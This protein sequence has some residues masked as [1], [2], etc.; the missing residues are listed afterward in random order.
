M[1]MFLG[2]ESQAVPKK[3]KT[4][5]QQQLKSAIELYR[6]GAYAASE[7]LCRKLIK[8][9]GAQDGSGWHLLGAV[10]RDSKRTEEAEVC[11]RKAIDIDPAN[12]DA[13]ANLGLCC[14]DEGRAAEGVAWQ[15]K[16]LAI[17]PLH[18]GA[19][20]NL[21]TLLFQADKIVDAEQTF[22]R[23][24]Q[25]GRSSA[26][27][28][29][30]AA[31]RKKLAKADEAVVMYRHW[32]AEHPD[33]V[34][35]ITELGLTLL[36]L[37][38]WNEAKEML[39]LGRTLAPDSVSI[40]ANLGM[41][42]RT[43]FKYAA[44]LEIWEAARDL[45]PDK[46]ELLVNL[47]SLYR[48]LGRTR[49]AEVT[50]RRALELR[51]DY[52]NAHNN[53]GNVF[54][55]EGRTREAREAFLKCLEFDQQH[56]CAWS[57]LLFT[58]QNIG[59]LSAELLAHDARRFGAALAAAELADG[60]QHANDARP[61]RILRI[62]YLSPDFLT[63][64]VSYFIEPILQHHDRSKVHITCFAN[65]SAIDP[66]TQR[67]QKL[68]DN[69]HFVEDLD[70]E[71]LKALIVAE[72]IDI[73][74]D[75]AGH[76]AKNRL[77][78]FARQP[79]P[80]QVSWIGYPDTTGLAAMHYRLTDAWADPVGKTEAWHTEKLIRLSQGFLCYRPPPDAPEPA[81]P[82]SLAGGSVTFG[83][84]N[85]LSKVD[86]E[87]IGLWS[88]IL[89]AAPGSRLMLKSLA[90]DAAGC[91]E[92]YL[93]AFAERGIERSRLVLI[94]KI[95][96]MQEHLAK[97]GEVDIALDT[98]PYHGTTTT[99][100]ALWMGV[101]VVTLAGVRHVSRVGVSLLS[102]VGAEEL[103]ARDEAH[104]IALAVE[105]ASDP[106]RLATYRR[107]LRG[108]MASSPLCDAAG[109]TAAVES[110][111]RQMWRDW[112]APAC[113]AENADAGEIFFRLM[114]K[115]RISFASGNWSEAAT[116][117]RK[118]TVVEPAA[119]DAWANLG[120]A[121]KGMG[122]IEEALASYR[123]AL[124]IKPDSAMV[125]ANMGAALLNKGD[126][127]AAEAACR[128]S[129]R[130]DPG[131][132][133]G[134]VNLALALAAKRDYQG[135]LAE[136][137]QALEL[138]LKSAETYCNM[139]ATLFELGRLAEA[140]ACC[141]KALAL[142][143][144]FTEARANLSTILI[145]Q[146]RLAEGLAEARKVLEQRPGFA[147]ANSN[148]LMTMQ[149]D[150]TVT[151]AE[152]CNAHREWGRR[153]GGKGGGFDFRDREGEEER[154][155]RLGF[156]STDFNAHPV[157]FFLE[158]LLAQLDRRTVE[159][160][161]YAANAYTDLVTDR[162]RALADYW[163]VIAG[164]DA[165]A[166]ARLVYDDRID[167]LFDL[168]G[169]TR[170][171]RL[172]M[173]ALRPAPLQATWLGYP[174]TT[175]LPEM[176][177]RLSDQHADPAGRTDEWCTE[178]LVRLPQSFLCYQLLPGAPA[179]A[180]APCLA[181]EGLTFGS[182]NNLSK[183]SPSAIRL[184][185]RVLLAT[186]GARL[187]VKAKALTDEGARRRLAAAFARAGLGED[188][189]ELRGWTPGPL[190]HLDQYK[191]VDIALDT[192]PYHGT[193]TTCEALSM[194]VPVVTLAGERHAARVGAS[195]LNGAGLAELVA[196]DEN[197]Y[198]DIAVRL[199]SDKQRLTRLR[200]GMRTR[201]HA[202]PLCDAPRF[203]RDFAEACRQMWREW[204]AASAGDKQITITA[205]KDDTMQSA[206]QQK[207]LKLPLPGGI[208]VCVPDN[209]SLMTPYIL[210]EQQDWFEDEIHFVRRLVEPG[211]AVI[212][213]G[214]NYGVYTLTIAKAVGTEGHVW[215]FEPARE[216]ADYLRAS[217]A[218]NGFDQVELIRAALSD[219]EGEAH[220]STNA[221]AELNTL[222]GALD[223][224]GETV[225]LTVL[226]AFL[227]QFSRYEVAFVK[228]DA[229]GEEPN[230]IRGG[231]RFFAEQSPLVMFEIKDA[232]TPNLHLVELFDR[233]GYASYRLVPG[234]NILVPFEATKPV[235]PFQLNLFACKADRARLLAERGLL[236]EPDQGEA[237]PVPDDDLWHQWLSDQPWAVG[238]LPK[239]DRCLTDAGSDAGRRHRDALNLYVLSK[240]MAL[241]AAGRVA[242]LAGS[243][244]LLAPFATETPNLPR[245]SSLARVAA[246]FGQRGAAV[247]AM[248]QL[249]TLLQKGGS[250]DLDE[251]FLPA[252]PRFDLLAPA[253]RLADWIICS[254]I[255]TLEKSCRYSSYFGPEQSRT[256]LETVAK[257]AFIGVAAKR[258]LELIERLARRAPSVAVASAN[259]FDVLPR[260]EAMISIVDIG[261]MM[262][263]D[264]QGP[265]AALV[266]QGY[267]Q[268]IGFEPNEAEC[269]KLNSR[270]EGTHR[271]YPF[272]IGDGEQA[273][274]YETNMTM[275]GSLLRPNKRML[276]QFTNL[277][278]LVTLVGEHAV[279]TRRLDD[280][281]GLEDVDVVKI[282]VQGT[283]L[284]V[285][286]G[287]AQVLSKALF[288]HTEVE[289]VELYE[290]QPLFA[291]IDQFLRAAG[292][293]FHTFEGFGQRSFK[294][295]IVSQDQNR[296]LRQLLWSDA[297]YVRDFLKFD[298]LP[299]QK[300]LKLAIIAHEMYRSYDLAYR[301]L[302]CLDKRKGTTLA[303][304]YLLFLHNH[305]IKPFCDV[306]KN[307]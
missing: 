185:S 30:L 273:T 215:A 19:L 91:R 297:I 114:D 191:D 92:V 255:E 241:S 57:N 292:F 46:P 207:M 201:L 63:H 225:R 126:I 85:S 130:I 283:E 262:L 270:F 157:G 188:R 54:R 168:N 240:N 160:F 83:S 144:T 183:I 7:R 233:L 137:E 139:S 56:W 277:H 202:S 218:E 87:L 269:K 31:C 242:A 305:S 187:L 177:F 45:E 304:A 260:P 230:V 256:L 25:N 236:A 161:L 231:D 43:M 69:W 74:V 138:G 247:G 167:I 162:L 289:F 28:R 239:W 14:A 169:H 268:V 181:G 22:S 116:A 263:G 198:V 32:L 252:G 300:L 266:R 153:F 122:K 229:E 272:F 123:K 64:S 220:L 254:V 66:M 6:Q 93:Q 110:A 27:V 23:A 8:Q 206:T 214:A 235:D 26:A 149:Y 306:N 179:V 286:K 84:F 245:L 280:L 132:A 250:F 98:Y 118:A 221:N 243:Y 288:V 155:L 59:G 298:L 120:A 107:A 257:R 50:L 81:A 142:Q 90:L 33:D 9:A 40:L 171:N 209:L 159:I 124:E 48:D 248:N 29:G 75:L 145:A 136:Y 12:A 226:D 178:R 294:P 99:C 281:V 197:E 61:E 2:S 174:D 151:P 232:N 163:R 279:T 73:L 44:A 234:L 275:T 77:P 205:P 213:I 204:C 21:G 128:Q 176:D 237:F 284:A 105:L 129:L 96:T 274:F 58:S 49:E 200:E 199:A 166:A 210:M 42:Y 195:I 301:A 244:E 156:V 184:W 158:P 267:A 51:P 302:A 271:F 219:H 186:A 228:L 164:L 143:P 34:A 17:N 86:P 97:Y 307:L 154:R 78:L 173:F 285:F 150:D 135:A 282:D 303:E 101:P 79:A 223:G 4:D 60:K 193:T 196:A 109:K 189:I 182:F 212:D 127:E 88:R 278:E 18:S 293:Q 148:L 190:G 67:L 258:R 1:T 224:K 216:T 203:A 291:E 287:A 140:A 47:G 141:A 146:G 106:H 211:M 265:Y 55:D 249:R 208:K 71:R 100:E 108:M 15:Q 175:G 103:I 70:D 170:G 38:R 299:D 259:L 37:H 192:F 72:R 246:E 95:P 80:V 238:M 11:F 295:L 125:Y 222:H 52:A 133:K 134:Y 53:L 68:A 104:Y 147:L 16:A 113:R 117:F 152:I 119:A 94:G 217:L 35:V 251:P 41:V 3:N 121:L 89:Q 172:D 264:D 76:T 115:G 65:Q 5:K 82:P 112:C 13:L 194:G 227:E 253:D 131:Y 102:Q 296:G 111:F 62:G 24:V 261:A 290:G 165:D 276:E 20:L 10:L 39:E 36:E 180:P